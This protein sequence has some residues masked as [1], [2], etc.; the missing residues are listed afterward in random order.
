[1]REFVR[2]REDLGGFRIGTVEEHH[3]R[4]VIGKYKTTKLIGIEHAASVVPDYAVD[5]GEHPSLLR[6]VPK[7]IQGTRPTGYSAGPAAN[8]PHSLAKSDCCVFRPHVIAL[9]SEMDLAI[10]RVL[11]V[12]TQ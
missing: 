12:F 1:M 11:E 4:V 9:E 3:R 8:E 7:Q 5:N 6:G 2:D 10:A